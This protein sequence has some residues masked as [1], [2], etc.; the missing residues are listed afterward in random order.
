MMM[1]VITL[2]LI[3]VFLTLGLMIFYYNRLLMNII[4]FEFNVISVMYFMYVSL[5]MMNMEF[6]MILYMIMMVCESVLVLCVL[7]R[8]VD[9]FGSDKVEILT[10]QTQ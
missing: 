9:L 2:S 3:L 7:V 8:Y 5:M 6:M 10:I 4:S 1:D